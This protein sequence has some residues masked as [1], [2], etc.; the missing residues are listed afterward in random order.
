MVWA[1][2]SRFKVKGLADKD[3]VY[4]C[5]FGRWNQG[6]RLMGLAGQ[7]HGSGFWVLV[8]ESWFELKVAD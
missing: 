1:D 2:A 7:K 3:P 8:A 5:E 6:L 4:G